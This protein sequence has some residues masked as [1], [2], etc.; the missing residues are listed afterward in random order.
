ME[1][2][3]LRHLGVRLEDPGLLLAPRFP[4]PVRRLRELS[5]HGFD[6]ALET[7]QF[8]LDRVFGDVFALGLQLAGDVHE[9]WPDG[10]PLGGRN[11]GELYVSTHEPIPPPR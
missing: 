7:F 1:L 4:E 8:F 5:H 3:I 2:R 6:G 10:D 11:A 9:G